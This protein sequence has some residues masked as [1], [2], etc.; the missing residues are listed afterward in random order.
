MQI[1]VNLNLDACITS[2][3][4]TT[5]REAIQEA[6][7]EQVQQLVRAEVLR[8]HK[9]TIAEWV[10]SGFDKVRFENGEVVIPLFTQEDV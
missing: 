8:V 1:T 4:E 2:G 9:A 5:L 7:T 6:I 3:Y 10:Q